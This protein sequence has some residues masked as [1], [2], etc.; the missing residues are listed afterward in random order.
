VSWDYKLL[1][2]RA[3]PRDPFYSEFL[4]E[5]DLRYFSSVVLE[6]TSEKMVGVS[7]QRTRRQGHVG[8]R[9]ISLMQR[10]CPHFQ[11]AYDMRTR[12]KAARNREN[13]L[14]NALDLLADGIAL[15]RRDG[16]IVYVNE[17]LRA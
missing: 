3:M 13:A 1:D 4:P 17:A 15:L 10:L 8:E 6:Q 7:I 16:R 5:L 9:E 2:E 12:L 11:R 14:E